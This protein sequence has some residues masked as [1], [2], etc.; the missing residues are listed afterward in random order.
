MV[1]FNAT[2]VNTGALRA[3]VDEFGADKNGKYGVANWDFLGSVEI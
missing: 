1:T 3:A 2:Q